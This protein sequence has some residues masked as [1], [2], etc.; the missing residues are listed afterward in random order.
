M[1]TIIDVERL[2]RSGETIMTRIPDTGKCIPGG[3]GANQ[4]VASARLCAGTARCS[5]QFVGQFGGDGHATALRQTL[6]DEKVDIS[7][8]GQHNDK[9]SGQGLVFLEEAGTV[10][11]VVIGGSNV[12]WPDNIDL[13]RDHLKSAA[14]LLLQR[15]IPERVNLLAAAAA[16]AANV[17]VFQDIGGEDRSISDEMLAL[18]TFVSPNLSELQ[19]LTGLPADTDAEVLAAAAMLQR[20][21][22]RNVLVTR[23]ERGALLLTDSG[24]VLTTSSAAVP[25]G[26][27]LDETG[28]GDSFRAAFAV[29]FIEGRPLAECM[30][31]AAASGAIAVSRVG[32]VPSLPFREECEQLVKTI[33]NESE[34]GACHGADEEPHGVLSGDKGLQ[35]DGGLDEIKFVPRFSSRLNAMKARSELWEGQ[36]MSVLDWIARQ[37]TIRG[38]SLV[39]LNFPEHFNSPQVTPEAVLHAVEA[40]GLAVGVIN[41]RYP[42]QFRRGALTH[43]DDAVRRQAV[44]LTVAGGAM[45]ERLGARGLVIWSAYDGYDYH[46]QM[47][48][49]KAWARTV[50]AC[51][52]VCD[53]H[54]DLKVMY[55]YKPTDEN[56]RFSV[57]GS[58][59]AA[60]LLMTT[61]LMYWLQ[62][63]N[64]T[65]HMGMDTFPQEEDPVREAEFNLRRARVHWDRARRLRN[66]G[67]DE[68]LTAHDALGALE[69]MEDLGEI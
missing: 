16:H 50:L 63:T 60:A 49:R 64:F 28:A 43:P 69:L 57:V 36:S 27:I 13:F 56:S 66:A 18:V 31:F 54:P 1:D 68:L 19:R 12:A 39:D 52:E 65:G 5:V 21:G 55:E 47:D 6:I 23:G 20:R 51:Q 3:K 22:A 25:G 2:P 8:S 62:L 67:L 32:A 41:M 33:S 61:E 29:A 30:R 26:R 45:A 10:S 24:G 46:M 4:A 34:R 35:Q 7:V 11:S 38:L 58:A 40:A 42:S 17:P 53:A 48:Y 44:D 15:E 9:T 59:G 37:G 14:V